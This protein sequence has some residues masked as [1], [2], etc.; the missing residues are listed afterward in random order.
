MWEGRSLSILLKGLVVPSRLWGRGYTNWPSPFF[1]AQAR[2]L[3][4]RGK[5]EELEIVR[6]MVNRTMYVFSP[7]I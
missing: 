7:L 2:D 1:G 5:A 6:D 3:Q 4:I